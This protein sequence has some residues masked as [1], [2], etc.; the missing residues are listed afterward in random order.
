MKN[1]TFAGLVGLALVWATGP[2]Q[3]DV[4]SYCEAYARDQA[5]HR[6]SGA[7]IFG[8]EPAV[9]P[10]EWEERK[11]LALADCLTLYTAKTEIETVAAEPEETVAAKPKAIEPKPTVKAKPRVR[12]LI[13]LTAPAQQDNSAAD[14]ATLVPGTRAWEDYC[15]AKYASFDRATGNYT[16]LTGKQRP[17]RVTKS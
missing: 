4:R 12:K 1:R 13:R 15:A 8:A 2:A 11:T 3:A 10:E 6:L 17:C 16:S 5:D 14:S 7:A 9:T